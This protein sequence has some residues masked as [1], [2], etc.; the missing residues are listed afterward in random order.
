VQSAPGSALFFL[1]VRSSKMV[2]E[3]VSIVAVAQYE[4]SMALRRVG[5]H[6]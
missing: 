5:I 1:V 2:Y 3:G 4:L 6:F